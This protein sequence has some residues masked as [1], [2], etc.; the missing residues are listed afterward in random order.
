MLQR[1]YPT[2]RLG[3][4]GS[5]PLAP[6]IKLFD[7]QGFFSSAP[8]IVPRQMRTNRRRFARFGAKTPEIVPNSVLGPFATEV[9]N[10]CTP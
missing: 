5:N 1:E 10:V 7:L 2:G 6:T 3:V 8:A 4:G 9:L